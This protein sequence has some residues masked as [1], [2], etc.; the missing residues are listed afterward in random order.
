MATYEFPITLY[1][2]GREEKEAWLDAVE[3]F[4]ASPGQP[5]SNF[6]VISDDDERLD[7]EEELELGDSVNGV[8]DDNYFYQEF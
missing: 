8:L 1:G 3:K 7:W 4:N 6:G 2:E 5:E